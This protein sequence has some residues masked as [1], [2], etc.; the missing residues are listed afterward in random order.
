MAANKLQNLV[1]I[2]HPVPSL[3]LFLEPEHSPSLVLCADRPPFQVLNLSSQPRQCMPTLVSFPGSHA[4]L[5]TSFGQPGPGQLYNHLTSVWGEPTVHERERL[6]G[7]EVDDTA[8]GHHVTLLDRQRLLGQAMDH[9]VM[10]WFGAI[11]GTLSFP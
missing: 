1:P 5:E 4:F 10:T 2:D 9:H 6:L 3:N 7:L 11:M 8:A